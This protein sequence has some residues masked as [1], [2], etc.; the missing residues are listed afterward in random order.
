M[1]DV[2]AGFGSY[3]LTE[4]CDEFMQDADENERDEVQPKHVG[5]FRV[6][7][8]LGIKNNNLDPVL[9]KRLPSGIAVYQSLFKD[10]YGSYDLTEICDEFMQDVDENERDEV[11]PKHV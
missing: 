7:L 9:V 6:H 3:D 11:L 5:G 2:T 4:I 10:V 8:L 1:D